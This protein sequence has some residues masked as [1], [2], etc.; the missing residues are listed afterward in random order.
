MIKNII[1]I[2]LFYII[3]SLLIAKPNNIEILKSALFTTKD[4]IAK[5]A[6]NA[7]EIFTGKETLTED[8]FFKEETEDNSE[9][10]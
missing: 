7:V 9:A 5:G 3:G 8:S 10:K 1:I 4:F 2:F 6:G